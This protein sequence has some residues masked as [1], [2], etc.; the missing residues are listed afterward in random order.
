[1]QNLIATTFEVVHYIAL[2]AV[3]Y[4][5]LQEVHLSRYNHKDKVILI[6][7]HANAAGK[8]DKW[9]DATGWCAYTTRGVHGFKARQPIPAL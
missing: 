3:H 2:Q 5:P 4:K 8:G 6:S 7:I 1:M 9:L